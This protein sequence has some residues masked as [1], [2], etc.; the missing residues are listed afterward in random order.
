VI[1]LALSHC[2]RP[3][4]N[5]EPRQV[6]RFCTTHPTDGASFTG[7]S[8][9]LQSDIT[10]GNECSATPLFPEKCVFCLV[11]ATWQNWGSSVNIVTM[12]RAGRSGIDT[13]R[14]QKIFIF[15]TASRPALGPTHPAIHR[16]PVALSPRVKRPGL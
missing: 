8:A 15:A 11:I 9:P 5:C 1:S 12:L 4:E 7:H 2:L 16:E 3:G 14:G 6:R 10:T 13:R